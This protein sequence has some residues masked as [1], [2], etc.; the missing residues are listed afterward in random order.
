M[1]GRDRP[2][3]VVLAILLVL[4]DVWTSLSANS[5]N[6][7][8]G[9]QQG[10]HQRKTTFQ[11][12]ETVTIYIEIHTSLGEVSNL[13]VSWLTPAGLIERSYSQVIQ[14]TSR[15]DVI[16]YSTLK[17]IKKG[18]LTRTFTGEDFDPTFFGQW[19]AIVYLNSEEMC[20]LKFD[21]MDY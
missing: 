12:H 10:N 7:F 9:T 21:M 13:N 8:I 14:P 3:V 15:R 20:R 5:V 18:M 16:Y 17:L 1:S 19:Q 4:S 11:P 2:L 6:A